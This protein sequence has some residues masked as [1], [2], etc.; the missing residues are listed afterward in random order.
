MLVG[1][2]C[3]F[4]EAYFLIYKNGIYMYNMRALVNNIMYIWKLLRESIL[5]VTILRKKLYLYQVMDVNWAYCN[6][7]AVYIHMKSFC[8]TPWTN[9]VFYICIH[10]YI[11]TQT[12]VSYINKT[13]K[14]LNKIVFI[15]FTLHSYCQL[16]IFNIKLLND[17]QHYQYH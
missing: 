9:T 7:F 16:V 11:Y 17:T 4:H 6:Y 8:T 15:I 1:I 3:H 10:I 2:C 5:K 14:I 13:G 12:H